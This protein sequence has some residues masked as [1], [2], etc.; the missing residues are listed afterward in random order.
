MISKIFLEFFPKISKF[1][2]IFPKITPPS[3]GLGIG[4]LVYCAIAALFVGIRRLRRASLTTPPRTHSTPRGD[5]PPSAG[6]VIGLLE[7]YAI[8]ALRGNTPPT[9]GIPNNSTP[10]TP[11]PLHPPSSKIDFFRGKKK[12]KIGFVL[13]DGNNLGYLGYLG[14]KR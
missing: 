8:A 12:L 6:L 11:H 9:A 13:I 10:H 14:E 5:T 7:Y 2:L 3:A 4:L 1:F